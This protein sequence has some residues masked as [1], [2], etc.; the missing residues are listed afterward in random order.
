MH[1]EGN[2]RKSQADG[3]TRDIF[4]KEVYLVGHELCLLLQ[5]CIARTIQT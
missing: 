4:I 3:I 1:L 5:R 2:A